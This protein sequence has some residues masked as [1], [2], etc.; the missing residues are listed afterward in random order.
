MATTSSIKEIAHRID[1]Q[2]PEDATWED[3]IYRNSVHHEIE[4][5]LKDAQEGRTVPV[6]EV[7]R[8]YGFSARDEKS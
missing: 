4:V 2:L 3:L 1:D 8:H 7:R 6:E 5:G